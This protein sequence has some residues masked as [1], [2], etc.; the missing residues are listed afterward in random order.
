[1]EVVS[2]TLK[3]IAKA[4]KLVEQYEID[5]HGCLIVVL[6]KKYGA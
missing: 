4:S 5:W 3:D 6:L 1:M 2:F